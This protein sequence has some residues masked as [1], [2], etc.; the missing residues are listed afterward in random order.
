M[1]GRRLQ[2]SKARAVLL[3]AARALAPS[4]QRSCS[5][6]WT[7]RAAVQFCSPSQRKLHATLMSNEGP[8]SL[9]ACLIRGLRGVSVT[10]FKRFT[11]TSGGRECGLQGLRWRNAGDRSW[12]SPRK[13]WSMRRLRPWRIIHST[14]STSLTAV[15][16]RTYV[17]GESLDSLSILCTRFPPPQRTEKAAVNSDTSFH[18]GV[19]YHISPESSFHHFLR[20]FSPVVS[21]LAAPRATGSG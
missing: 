10:D 6:V 3:P 11:S 12:E 2:G 4:L 7:G 18:T 9:P 19:Q 21:T 1:T 15:R 13:H 14:Y 20:S 17:C 8:T 5:S 16:P